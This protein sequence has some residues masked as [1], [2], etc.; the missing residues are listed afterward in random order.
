MHLRFL[1]TFALLA[2]L[3]IACKKEAGPDEIIL[4]SYGTIKYHLTDNEGKPVTDATVKLFQR[5]GNENMQLYEKR[6]DANGLV[7]FDKLNHG[8]YGVSTEKAMV[9]AAEYVVNH[10]FQ[11][12]SGVD[13]TMTTDITSFGNDITIFAYETDYWNTDRRDPLANYGVV[14]I[15]SYLGG[16]NEYQVTPELERLAFAI[17]YTD[18]NGKLLIKRVPA[19]F[20]YT[21]YIFDRSTKKIIGSSII[22]TGGWGHNIDLDLPIYK[23]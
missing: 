23:N 3:L 18:N 10:T 7:D 5:F 4:K 20:P 9:G 11:V 22:S 14:T 6:T 15:Q 21:F 2:S 17:G 1:L 19:A 13:T 12:N 16:F 8:T